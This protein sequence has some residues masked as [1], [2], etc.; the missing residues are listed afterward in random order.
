MTLSQEVLEGWLP[1]CPRLLEMDRFIGLEFRDDVKGQLQVTHIWCQ[2]HSKKA[3]TKVWR[4]LE[5]EIRYREA[6]QPGSDICIHMTVWVNILAPFG[7]AELA[8]KEPYLQALRSPPVYPDHLARLIT[9]LRPSN[10]MDPNQALDD[11]C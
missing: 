2:M 3:Q 7:Q 6:H 1:M 8:D 9:F 5:R 10:P 4:R 11:P